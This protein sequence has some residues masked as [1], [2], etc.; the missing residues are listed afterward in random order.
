MSSSAGGG[1]GIEVRAGMHAEAAEQPLLSG[2]RI[3]DRT[4]RSAA[5]TDTF[6]ARIS[7]SQSRAAASSAARSAAVQAG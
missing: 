3:S 5:A 2:A 4:G 6:S 1:I 7:S